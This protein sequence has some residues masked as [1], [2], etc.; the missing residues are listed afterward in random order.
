MAAQIKGK[1]IKGKLFESAFLEKITRASPW[2]IFMLYIPLNSYLLYYAITHIYGSVGMVIG[3]FILGAFSWTLAE[4]LIHRF[5]FHFP[6]TSE[7]SKKIT[8][9]IHGIH[10]DYPRDKERLVMP[11]IPS[12]MLASIFWS[13]FYVLL[14]FDVA[15]VFFPGFVSGY[16]CYMTMH[17]CIHTI[18]NPPKFLRSLWRHHQLH[19]HRPEPVA[20]GVSTVIWDY[21]F[22]TMPSDSPKKTTKSV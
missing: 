2:Q 9:T 20:F 10:H 12:V 14:G 1:P 4:Y 15:L 22:G 3:I 7:L 5:G 13:L 16:L 11:V 6:G 8:Y 17:Y 19:H 18:T 21:I